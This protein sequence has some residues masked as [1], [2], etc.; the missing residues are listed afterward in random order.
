MKTGVLVG[1]TAFLVVAF[2]AEMA[3]AIPAFARKYETSCVTCHSA[4]P[5]LNSFGEA[6]RLSGYQY[7]EDDEEMTKD[8]P[9]SLGSEAYKR[10]FPDAVWPNDIPG[11]PPISLRVSSA[12][13]YV[14]DATI[15]TEF[16]APSLNLM[17]AGTLGESIGFYAGAH[18]FE[19]GETGSIDRAFLQI[20]NIFGG[21]LPDKSLNLRIG[22]FIPNMVPFANHRGLSLTPYAYNTY[23]ALEE[24]FAGGHA[25]GGGGETFGIEDFQLGLEASGF[26]GSR[27]RWGAGIVNGN[28]PGGESNSAKD[29]YGRLAV[30]LGGM[31]FDGSNAP[32]EASGKNW[33]D[34]SVTLGVIGFLGSYPN[35]TTAGPMDLERNRYGVDVN[36]LVHD[37]NLFGGYLRGSDETME[38]MTLRKADY[39]IWF[40]EANYVVFPWLIGVGRFEQADPDEAATIERF[41]AGFTTLYRANVKFVFESAFDPDVEG[42]TDLQFKVDFAM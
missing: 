19:E 27:W 31:G 17:A 42:F 34:D 40:A 26:V 21:G 30:K 6:F 23:S 33:R 18:L 2:T 38:S 10:V 20:N 25:H 29:G 11:K 22:Q 3:S 39:G 32:A 5:K 36:I 1:I 14:D 8:E 16:V 15:D 37:L 12:F 24:G 35:G 9:V 41:V 7:P 4:F 28:G 13:N